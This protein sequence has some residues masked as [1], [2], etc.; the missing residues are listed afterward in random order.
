MSEKSLVVHVA[1][2]ELLPNRATRK[3][4]QPSPANYQP[5]EASDRP[6]V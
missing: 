1:L 6:N 2:S 3:L 4:N 5:G